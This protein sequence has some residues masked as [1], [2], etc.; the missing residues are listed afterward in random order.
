M[1]HAFDYDKPF[2]YNAPDPEPEE[3][4]PQS[5][6]LLTEQEWDDLAFMLKFYEAETRWIRYAKAD[7][8]GVDRITRRRALAQRII[9][10]AS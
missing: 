1:T 9:E 6:L 3:D 2:D 4:A 10:A 5:A 8:T 7:T